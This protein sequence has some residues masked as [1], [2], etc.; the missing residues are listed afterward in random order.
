MLWGRECDCVCV[1]LKLSRWVWVLHGCELSMYTINFCF[2]F[3]LSPSVY[4]YW[5]W[6]LAEHILVSM[7]AVGRMCGDLYILTK[8]T[9]CLL[10]VPHSFQRDFPTVLWLFM[11][12]LWVCVC[13]SLY[14]SC[15]N[16]IWLSMSFFWVCMWVNYWLSLSL[17]DCVTM[18]DRDSG[19]CVCQSV[20]LT[21]CVLLWVWLCVRI[22]EWAGLRRRERER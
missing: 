5:R 4:I 3:A 22:R 14:K 11:C 17:S 6:S 19:F 13:L 2:L 21:V 16:F 15:R 18:S 8:L 1:Y 12:V 10:L 20:S 7:F 9:I